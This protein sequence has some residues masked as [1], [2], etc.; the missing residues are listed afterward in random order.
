GTVQTTE[1]EIYGSGVV[2]VSPPT[3]W[4]ARGAAGVPGNISIQSPRGNIVATLGGILQLALGGRSFCGPS[5]T[6]VAGI[7]GSGSGAAFPGDIDLG[8]NGAIGGTISI[9]ANGSVHGSAVSN[10]CSTYTETELLVAAG[11]P[12]HLSSSVR[13]LPPLAY[14]WYKSGAMIDGA[15]RS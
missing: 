10:S 15:T 6:L 1:E 5:I 11:A 9:T 14:Q 7:A 13:L 4:L 2:A 12:L 8:V 3:E